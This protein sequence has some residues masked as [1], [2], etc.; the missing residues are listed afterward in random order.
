MRAHGV[1]REVCSVQ[2]NVQCAV[3]AEGWTASSVCNKTSSSPRLAV[4]QQQLS[5]AS[6]RARQKTPKL[7]FVLSRVEGE[8]GRGMQ[9][10][11]QS[12]VEMWL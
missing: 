9:M 10:Q 6:D 8:R 4:A 5:A 7:R 11:I 2:C 12:N 3:Q 1:Q